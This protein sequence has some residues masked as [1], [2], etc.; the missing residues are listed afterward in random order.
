MWRQLLRWFTP[1]LLA[2]C[3]LAPVAAQTT[4]KAKDDTTITRGADAGPNVSFKMEGKTYFLEH[5]LALCGAALL[6]VIIGAPGRK[7]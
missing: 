1:L 4:P 7:A 5:V 2:G 3:L 6:V